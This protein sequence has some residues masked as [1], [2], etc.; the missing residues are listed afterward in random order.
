MVARHST[1][2]HKGPAF[3]FE[4]KVGV[5]LVLFLGIGGLVLGGMYTW[6]NLR[7]PF[8]DIL[9][10]QGET[11]MP[12]AQREAA[13]LEAQK[14]MDTDG[15]TLSD[16]DELYIFKTS[17]YLSD[18]DSDGLNDANEISAGKDP[19]CPTGQNCGYY[20][21]ADEND[22][23]AQDVVDNLPGSTLGLDF[24]NVDIENEQDVVDMFSAMTAD[25]IRG[26]LLQAGVDQKTLDDLSDQE[27]LALLDSALSKSEDM[28]G[29]VDQVED[30]QVEE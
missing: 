16:Y 18:S 28:S 12:L 22:M 2:K 14:G 10:Y 30:Y 26:M 1:N 29:L 17:P 8:Y 24:S 6:Q 25:Q 5:V 9:Y 3:S 15:D 23:T 20:F 13:E 7:R 27:V 11:M 4:R 21:A 19:N